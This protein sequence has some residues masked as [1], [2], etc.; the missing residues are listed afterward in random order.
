M[1]CSLF[2]HCQRH[3]AVREQHS[4]QFRMDVLDATNRP[5]PCDLH[6]YHLEE[7]LSIKLQTQRL[8]LELFFWEKRN[9]IFVRRLRNG[10]RNDSSI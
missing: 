8:Q 1:S 10:G 3:D 5:N 4:A 7:L 6:S 9:V 2:A